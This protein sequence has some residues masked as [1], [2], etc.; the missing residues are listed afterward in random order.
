MASED[1]KNSGVPAP[2]PEG[3][4]RKVPLKSQK[5]FQRDLRRQPPSEVLAF[6][7]V[8]M[9]HKEMVLRTQLMCMAPVTAPLSTPRQSRCKCTELLASFYPGKGIVH[10]G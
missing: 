2:L 6:S 3:V 7:M 5:L 1:S 9:S 4:A 8:L 10:S